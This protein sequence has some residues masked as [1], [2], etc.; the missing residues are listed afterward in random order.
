MLIIYL[1]FWSTPSSRAEVC[2]LLPN[3]NTVKLLT[4]RPWC[5]Y[6]GWHHKFWLLQLQRWPGAGNL[7]VAALS[8]ATNGRSIASAAFAGVLHSG[9]DVSGTNTQ[10]L[11]RPPTG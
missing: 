6:E 9:V 4:S 8:I 10:A 11:R 7:K 1:Q 2:L 3:A 5:P